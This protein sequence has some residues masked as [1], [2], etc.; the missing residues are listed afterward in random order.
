[1]SNE[2][3]A[4]ETAGTVPEWL[5]VIVNG[6]DAPEPSYA[7]LTTA[8]PSTVGIFA[9]P[10][11]APSAPL[12]RPPT[13]RGG[14]CGTI[15]VDKLETLCDALK[16]RSGEL[17][18]DDVRALGLLPFVLSALEA[19]GP[20]CLLPPP[21]V[22]ATHVTAGQENMSTDDDFSNFYD[23]YPA[24][25]DDAAQGGVAGGAVAPATFGSKGTGF[26]WVP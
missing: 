15:T 14:P 12:T 26:G 10:T 1:M 20:D 5:R 19:P 2:R 24:E 17:D 8:H 13:G 16:K 11:A 23:E 21:V 4:I 18:R 22:P 25:E 3:D 7:T 9:S 6:P